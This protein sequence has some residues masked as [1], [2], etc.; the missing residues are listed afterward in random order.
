MKR[1]LLF[2]L[3]T[4]LLGY[5]S[6]GYSQLKY[7]AI[8]KSKDPS[9]ISNQISEEFMPVIGVWQWSERNLQPG[10]FKN[11]IDM[12]SK[13]SPFNLLIPFLRF[14]NTE[15]VEDAVIKQVKLAAEYA[16]ENDLV[17]VPDLDIRNA[18]RA[19]RSQ[20]PDEM[21]EMLR[22]QN[23]G[24]AVD[25]PTEL[26]VSA[27]INMNDHYTGGNIPSYY[28]IKNSVM[29]VYGFKSSPDGIDKNSIR[30]ITNNCTI[31]NIS[32]DSVKIILPA[33]MSNLTEACAMVSF[34]LFYPDVFAPHL[35]EFQRSII[36]KYSDAPLAGVCK[37]EWGF[38]PYFPR[39][40][41]PGGY[42]FWYS[43]ASALEYS[44]KTGGRELLYDCF[45]MAGNIKSMEVERQV[46]VNNFMEMVLRR[47]IAIENGYYDAVKE[48]FGPDAAVM[49]HPTWWPY[50]DYNEYRK[51]GLDWWGIKRD[52][53]QTDEIVPFAVRSALTKKY[54]SPVWYNMY[55]TK[56]LPV[57]VWSSALAN[58][59]INYL[60]HSSLYNSDVMRAETRIRLLNYISQS[61]MDCPVA[62]IFGHAA[63]VNWAG[64]YHNDA[65][66]KLADTLWYSGYR[67]D[68]IPTSEIENGSLK[69]DKEGW[70]T[71]GKQRYSAVVLYHPEYEKSTTSDFFRKAADGKTALFSVGNW[72]LDF[73]GKSIT[74]MNALPAKMTK[75]KDY[76]EA[77]LKTSEAL[78]K[79]NILKQTPATDTLDSRYFTLRGFSTISYFPP[80]TGFS[81]MIDGTLIQVAGT[82]NISGDPIKSDF[83]IENYS[84]KIDAIGVAG[85]RL[86]K[87]GNL[88]ALAAS[89]LKS[90]RTGKFEIT[91]DERLDVALWIDP[92]GQWMGV[93]QGLS[94]EIPKVLTDITKNWT[95]L[96][97]PSLPQGFRQSP[98]L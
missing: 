57:Q 58:G 91:L 11:T 22:L 74:L 7:P 87:D 1:F 19:F 46:A 51:N 54:N 83:K 45:L 5:S 92:K 69:V 76:R 40:V 12:A 68:L 9:G 21:Q 59:R 49:V 13:N 26:I 25:K 65:G 78:N 52:W 15:V 29:R 81:R 70:I 43:K 10:G 96:S 79:R 42:D 75:T 64:P 95:R 53:A 71:Y 55:Y 33:S 8:S 37:D 89:G 66:M 39:Y 88:Q 85:V 6:S 50:P 90:F 35:L 41:N 60:D 86:D 38:P 31:V 24:L 47:N 94:G 34:T 80:T 63:T 72:T 4:A 97:L 62:V 18:R 28:P 2:S 98:L 77:F 93:I 32:K 30:D 27:V 82:K 48:T 3:I 20:H 17:L 73:N 16:A 36:K 61:P 44:K 56:L 84:C 67:T 14:G 23:A